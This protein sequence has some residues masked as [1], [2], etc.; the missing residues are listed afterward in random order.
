MIVYVTVSNSGNPIFILESKNFIT[1]NG[2]NSLVSIIKFQFNLSL[3]DLIF[4]IFPSSKN[5]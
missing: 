2:N 5:L 4:K 3:E 1:S